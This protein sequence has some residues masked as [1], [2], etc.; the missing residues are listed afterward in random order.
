MTVLI[1]GAPTVY[2]YVPLAERHNILKQNSVRG[3][4]TQNSNTFEVR[5]SVLLRSG[6]IQALY[7]TLQH[8]LT[9]NSCKYVQKVFKQILC[10][11]MWLNLCEN[12]KKI[13]LRFA[14]QKCI[15]L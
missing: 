6:T 10:I 9:I 12:T 8:N 2:N 15:F 4:K 13:A 5:Y 1:L 3:A 7:N 11:F 14:P